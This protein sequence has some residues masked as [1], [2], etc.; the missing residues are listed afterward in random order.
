MALKA[1]L[2]GGAL[3]YAI[4]VALICAFICASLLL[5]AHLNTMEWAHLDEMQQVTNNCRSGIEL[6]LSELPPTT[7]KDSL[8]YELGPTDRVELKEEKWGI[9]TLIYSKAEK[10]KASLKKAAI[11]GQLPVDER[12]A[13]YL[14]DKN[15]PLSVCGETRLRGTC[16]LPEAGIKRAYIEGKTF[17]GDQLVEGDRKLIGKEFPKLRNSILQ[18]IDSVRGLSFAAEKMLSEMGEEEAHHSF[19]K[20]ADLIFADVELPEM[21][22]QGKR[23]LFSN[24]PFTVSG[25]R[26]LE[27]VIVVAPVIYFEEGS[28]STG[29]FIATDSIRVMKGAQLQYPSALMVY[30]KPG[31]LPGTISIEEEARVSGVVVLYNREQQRQRNRSTIDIDKGAV[32]EGVVY[33]NTTVGLKGTV[34]G[35]LY[36]QSFY[37]ETMSSKYENHLLDAVVDATNLDEHFADLIWLDGP[38]NKCIAKWVD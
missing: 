14:K 7:F 8:N 17:T 37:L 2:K 4:L 3:Y 16:Y 33:A 28:V 30:G 12:P 5:Y 6:M 36:T 34:M 38:A 18:S 1:D 9:H 29:Q 15:R 35:T 31:S 23:I 19:W 26:M 13:L 11:V 24:D 20:K 27:D 25:D 22:L 32:V 21:K 10:G